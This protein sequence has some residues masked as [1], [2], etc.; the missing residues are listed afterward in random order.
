MINTVIVIAVL[1]V[2]GLLYVQIEHHARKIKITV[3]ILV[4]VSIY[5]SLSSVFSTN[6]IDATSPSGI[7][8]ATLLYVDWVS[9]T[10]VKLWDVGAETTH[11]VG[12]AIKVNGTE[13]SLLE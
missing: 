12:N 11:M 5:F 6:E 10:S 3:L 7:M 1:L 8:D 2:I 4:I 13:E 9:S